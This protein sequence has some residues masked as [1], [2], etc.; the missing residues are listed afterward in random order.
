MKNTAII[1][2]YSTQKEIY[3]FIERCPVKPYE[4]RL[5]LER[6]DGAGR[7][8]ISDLDSQDIRISKYQTAE[9]WSRGAVPKTMDINLQGKSFSLRNCYLQRAYL[10]GYKISEGKLIFVLGGNPGNPDRL[11]WPDTYADIT[12]RDISLTIGEIEETDRRKLTD[13]LK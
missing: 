3:G 6:P 1:K 5:T 12:A 11:S 10:D 7:L 2:P 4:M 9:E 8:V 13:W